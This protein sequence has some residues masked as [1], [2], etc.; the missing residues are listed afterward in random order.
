MPNDTNW[1]MYN[2]KYSWHGTDYDP[3]NKKILLQIY[4]VYSKKELLEKSR[5]KY[6]DYVVEF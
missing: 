1:F 3:E 4:S 2:D 6:K 5:I